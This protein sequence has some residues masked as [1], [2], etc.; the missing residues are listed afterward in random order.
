MYHYRIARVYCLWGCRTSNHS[1]RSLGPDRWAGSGAGPGVAGMARP[2]VGA[3]GRAARPR[4]AATSHAH[5]AVHA[6]GQ[7]AAALHQNQPQPLAREYLT[8]ELYIDN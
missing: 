3:G 8:K 5:Q 4:P 7:A 2:V 6:T 1:E